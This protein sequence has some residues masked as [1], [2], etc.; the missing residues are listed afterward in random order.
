[1]K[2]ADFEAWCVE[3]PWADEITLSPAEAVELTNDMLDHEP[4]SPPS[5][6]DVPP[7]TEPVGVC[8]E[9]LRRPGRPKRTVRLVVA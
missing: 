9:S 8:I 3:N 4:Y 6:E 2:L 7:P 5:Y 1:M